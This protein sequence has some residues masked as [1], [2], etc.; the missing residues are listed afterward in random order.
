MVPL[1]AV[2]GL[3]GVAYVAYSSLRRHLHE[4]EDRERRVEESKRSSGR[5]ERDAKTG[6]Y[7]PSD[8]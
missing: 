4:I 2:L 3:G 1:I 6:R 7:R 5:L 8:D